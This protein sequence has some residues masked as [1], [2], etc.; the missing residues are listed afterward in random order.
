MSRL[1]APADL[2]DL[3]RSTFAKA[4]AEGELNYFPTQVTILYANKVPF[5]LRFSPALANKPK[6]PPAPKEP[7]RKPFNPFEDPT[8]A[9]RVTDLGDAHRL[10][11]NKFAVVPEHFILATTAFK[12]QTHVLEA[13]DLAATMACIEAYGDEDKASTTGGGLFAFFNCGAFSGASQPHRHIQLLPIAR[14]RDG[15]E[16]VGDQTSWDVLADKLGTHRP[17]FATFSECVRPDMSAAELHAAYLR[18][19]RRA[20]RAVARHGGEGGG[21]QEAPETGEARISYNMAMTRRTLVVSPRLAEGADV[22]ASSGRVLGT[23]SLNGTVL[24]GTALVKSE[25]EWDTLRRDPSGFER[26]LGGIGV[27]ADEVDDETE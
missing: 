10:V 15:L 25:L 5:Q 22:A 8:P 13:G 27:P 12:A 18:L 1:R 26:V 4:L 9:L 2:P 19:Y 14:M 16:G 23:M 20:C 6:G 17:P 24:A 21:D 3:V 11:L 7:G